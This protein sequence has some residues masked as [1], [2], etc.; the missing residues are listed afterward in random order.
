MRKVSVLTVF[1]AGLAACLATHAAD[2]LGDELN[3]FASALEREDYSL[4]L[5]MLESPNFIHYVDGDGQTA[6]FA[7]AYL[8]NDDVLKALLK[9]E[10]DIHQRDADGATALHYGAGGPGPRNAANTLLIAGADPNAADNNGLTP[11]MMAA[12][13]GRQ[14]HANMLL[15]RGAEPDMIDR[16]GGTAL[17]YAISKDQFGI[18]Q[19]LLKH[20]ASPTLGRG[21][22]TPLMLAQEL[23]HTRIAE[24]IE[25]YLE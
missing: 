1:V 10:P 12:M 18:V 16:R 6:L 17:L 20:G 25:R 19:L 11:L 24:W 9:L 22:A 4:A 3:R 2:D 21:D 8:G 23:G 5:R 13:N 14:L 15:L 7:A